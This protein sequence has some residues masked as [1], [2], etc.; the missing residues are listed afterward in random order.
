MRLLVYSHDAF[1]LG[2]IRRMLAICEHLLD[3]IPNLTILLLSG[4]P[5]LQGFRIPKNLDY[6][7][8]PCLNRGTTGKIAA[9]YL[10]MDADE[11][12]KLRS[13]LIRSAAASFKPD[14]VLVDKKPYGIQ[15]ELMPMLNYLKAA[16]PKP[17]MVLLLRDILDAPEVTIADWQKH[18]FDQ[19]VEEFYDRLLIVG[20]PE[21]FDFCKAYQLPS[22]IAY[23]SRYCGYL[24]RSAGSKSRAEVRQELGVGECDRLIVVT[25]G[26]GEDGYPIVNAFLQGTAA[27]MFRSLVI[28][29]P[30]M[31]SPQKQSLYQ[32]AEKLPLAEMR[33]FSDDLMSYLAAADVVV[34]MGGYNTICEVLSAGRRAVIVPR[35]K[36]SQEQI[37]RTNCMARFGFFDAIEPDQLTP[38]KVSQVIQK[39]L[40]QPINR[41]PAIDLNGLSRIAHHLSSLMQEPPRDAVTQ[42]TYAVR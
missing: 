4:S 10:G 12:V 14:L 32:T 20:T 6:I 28:C 5:M 22:N 34:A 29:G 35:V 39:Q 8:L 40:E 27:K 33:E 13:K 21:V 3:T 7:K 2:N 15:N 37:V 16:Q 1:G 9:K 31:P 25:P 42:R 17:K 30:E 18:G 36:P 38:E 23:K 19:T 26:G 24:G 41:R 11:T